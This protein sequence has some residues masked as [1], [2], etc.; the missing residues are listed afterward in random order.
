MRKVSDH[1]W[2]LSFLKFVLIV[3][4]LWAIFLKSLLLLYLS[5]PSFSLLPTLPFSLP[6][7]LP[8]LCMSSLLPLSFKIY[9]FLQLKFW[10]TFL[11]MPF[12][13]LKKFQK[14]SKITFVKNLWNLDLSGSLSPTFFSL[15]NSVLSEPET[16]SPFSSTAYYHFENGCWSKKPAGFRKSPHSQ[17]PVISKYVKIKLEP[18][19]SLAFGVSGSNVWFYIVW[20]CLCGLWKIVVSFQNFILRSRESSCG[21][22]G[23]F[24]AL[25]QFLCL[26]YVVWFRRGC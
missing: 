15:W 3:S 10:V 12:V 20:Y 19:K 4:V 6:P 1:I 5:F 13:S 23:V 16:S 26:S 17:A 14:H 21:Y 8:F 22:Y 2:C 9:R 11:G 24:W 7:F 25:D 18:E